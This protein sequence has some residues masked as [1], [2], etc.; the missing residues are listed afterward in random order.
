MCRL[1]WYLEI[2]IRSLKYFWF[3]I[4]IPD[5]LITLGLYNFVRGRRL[6]SVEFPIGNW[7]KYSN[8]F[9][10]LKYYFFCITQLDGN[11][12]IFRFEDKILLNV[13]NTVIR[14]TSFIFLFRRKNTLRNEWNCNFGILFSKEIANNFS[15]FIDN[16]NEFYLGINIS[17][18]FAL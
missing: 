13:Y 15:R 11:P 3:A 16:A 2:E 5:A 18:F 8:E 9:T 7:M 14:G 17:I 12:H 10:I 1:C 6:K 4:I